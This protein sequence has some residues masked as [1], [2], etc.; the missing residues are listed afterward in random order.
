VEATGSI[1]DSWWKQRQGR[2]RAG[3]HDD[4]LAYAEA[5]A[6]SGYRVTKSS[7]W[8]RTAIHFDGSSSVTVLVG[9]HHGHA[10]FST[11]A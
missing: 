3:C 6:A 10:T 7:S 9:C 2:I 5:W 8:I 1:G 11:L 4:K